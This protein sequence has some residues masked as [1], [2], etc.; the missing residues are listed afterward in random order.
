MAFRGQLQPWFSLEK[1]Y[2]IHLFQAFDMITQALLG[3]KS[4]F[5]SP[6]KIQFLRCQQKHLKSI[7]HDDFSLLIT[8]IA[9]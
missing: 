4:A 1:C 8:R 7:C 2:M 9:Y 5:R 6:G 3:H